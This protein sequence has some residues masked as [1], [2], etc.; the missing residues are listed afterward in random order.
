M[1]MTEVTVKRMSMT[2]IIKKAKVVGIDPG[3]MNKAELI[4]AI[5]TAENRSACFGT[6]DG[7]CAYA[8]CCFVQDCFQISLAEH[9]QAEEYFKQ[10]I[11]ELTAA[12]EQLQ[13]EI[14]EHQQ[15]QD[16][17]E[18]Y[19]GNLEQRIEQQIIKL[20]A[21]NDKFQCQS[22]EYQR[23]EQYLVQLQ[24]NL[25]SIK[26]I[27]KKQLEL[28][29]VTPEV[30]ESSTSTPEPVD[31]TSN[32]CVGGRVKREKFR[33]EMRKNLWKNTGHGQVES[34]AATNQALVDKGTG[35]FREELFLTS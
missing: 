22:D 32:W 12:I 3:E 28:R 13:Q 29:K 4:R 17:L 5:Q 30:F 25:E 27:V 14:S 9:K 18:Q 16:E 1:V 20:A 11:G 33:R 15:T 8:E 7:Q 35:Q 34:T 31:C 19:C 26:S 21:T 10:Q 24:A 2:E 6:S 23:L